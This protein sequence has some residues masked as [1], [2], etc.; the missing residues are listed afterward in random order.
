VPDTRRRAVSMSVLSK[1]QP[2]CII[3][4]A[5]LG[6]LLGKTSSTI[7][8]NAD[9][10]I[11]VFLMGMLFLVF[12]GV[13]FG[14]KPGKFLGINIRFSTAALIINFVWTPLFALLLAKTFFPG[15]TSLQTGFI[16]LLVT[17]C[18]DW[19][20]IFTGLANG[21][22]ALAASILPLNLILQILL[23]PLYLLVFMGE[24]LSIDFQTIARCIGMVLVIPFMAAGGIKW[25]AGKTSRAPGYSLFAKIMARNEDLQCILLCLAIAAMFASQGS[26]LL[27]HVMLFALLLFPLLLFFAVNLLLSLFVGKKLKLP[28]YDRIPLLF[29]TLARNSPISLAIA[30]F[31]FPSE[32][33]IAL[34]LVMGPLIEL[35]V[36]ALDAAILKKAGEKERPL[37]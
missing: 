23:L 4:S 6:I 22:V 37:E 26:V 15:E 16:M 13:T 14:G 35:P 10:F 25:L 34:V 2:L 3:L 9:S 1:F 11:T 27:A 8:E 33:V 7:E 31:T 29:T 5:F 36:L 28:F 32:P 12:L 30:V 19:Y 18:T 21:N 24:N 17:P 20:L